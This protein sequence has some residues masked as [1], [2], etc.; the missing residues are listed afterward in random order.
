VTNTSA[1]NSNKNKLRSQKSF[2]IQAPGLVVFLPKIYAKQFNQTQATNLP[3]TG[4][5]LTNIF[6]GVNYSMA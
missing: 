1:Y 4:T 2:M 3:F 6:T 5:H